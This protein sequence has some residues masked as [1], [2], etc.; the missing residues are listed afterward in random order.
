[1]TSTIG[2]LLLQKKN[3]PKD[4]VVYI[5]QEKLMISKEEVK[6]R[7]GLVIVEHRLLA[8]ESDILPFSLSQ[9]QFWNK[10]FRRKGRKWEKPRKLFDYSKYVGFIK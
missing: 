9:W 8:Q 5:I 4:V 2:N 3:I 6:R 1:M 10:L 7:Y